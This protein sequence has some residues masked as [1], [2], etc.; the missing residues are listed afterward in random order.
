MTEVYRNKRPTP[1][2]KCKDRY[3]GCHDHCTKPEYLEYEAEQQKIRE[4]RAA[5]RC[6]A[7]VTSERDPNQYRCSKKR[8]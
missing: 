7:W 3:P 6:S 4:A 8:K 2:W 5:Y 1:C